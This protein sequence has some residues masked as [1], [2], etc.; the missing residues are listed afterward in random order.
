MDRIYESVLCEHFDENG[1]MLFFAGPRQVGKTTCGQKPSNPDEAILYLNWDNEEDRLLL[2]DGPSRVIEH[3]QLDVARES[4]PRLVFDELHKFPNWKNW[5]K[6]FYDTYRDKAH[7][8]VTGSSRLDVYRR[9]ADS[10]MGRYF[11]YRVHPFSVAECV[12]TEFTEQLYRSPVRVEED[13]FHALIN[14][15]G[16]PEPFLKQN[17][18]FVNRW[19][20]MRRD[21]LFKEDIKD[22]TD[23]REIGL[24]SLLANILSRQAACSINYTSLSKHIHVS[25][26]TIKRWLQVLEEFYFCFTIQ[27]WHKNVTRSLLKEPKLYLWDWSE[28]SDVGQRAENF[29]A[30]HLLK[31]VH[32]WTDIGLGEFGLY[33]CR[34]LEK[35]EVDFVVTKNNAPWFLVEVKQSGKT[36]LSGHLGYFQQQLGAEHAFQVALDLEFRELD[37]FSYGQ[38]VIVPAQTFLSQLI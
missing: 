38:P 28:V 29:V 23:I 34:D 12:R 15:G 2:L 10:L 13:L 35:R 32:Y 6:G 18:R 30:S 17:M 1:Q 11:P 27:P 8:V 31:A 33:Y 9:G 20:R 16:F 24:L 22:L 25:V 37:C 36:P 3:F 7:V 26:P 21:L 14:F 5:L 4:K 19:Q